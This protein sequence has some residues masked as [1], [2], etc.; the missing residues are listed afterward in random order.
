MIKILDF[1][2]EYIKPLLFL[3]KGLTFGFLTLNIFF[4]CL[5]ARPHHNQIF[6]LI[7]EGKLLFVD[8]LIKVGFSNW[9]LIVIGLCLSLVLSDHLPIMV[10]INKYFIL[11][12]KGCLAFLTW[13]LTS[14]PIMYF[15]VQFK[16]IDK[17]VL[18]NFYF[19]HPNLGDPQVWLYYFT[20]TLYGSIMVE[21]L[22][23][24]I[25]E[26]RYK[27]NKRT[28]KNSLNEILSIPPNSSMTLNIKG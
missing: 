16:L 9:L 7:F 20:L 27:R 24:L 1:Y 14:V 3:E 2:N 4:T 5:K 6:N 11:T 19:N 13:L 8:A 17:Q 23:V 15:S 26:I 25:K 12:V 21:L 28:T 10:R 18:Q 22:R